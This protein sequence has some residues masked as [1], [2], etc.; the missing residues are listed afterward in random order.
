MKSNKKSFLLHVDSLDI[1]DEL[2]DEQAGILFKSIRAYQRGEEI[3]T[4]SFIR[5][6]FSPFKNQFIRDNEKYILICKARAEAGS[7]GGTAKTTNSKQKLASATNS[8]Q[9]IAN[10]ADND[11]DSDSDSVS[12]SDLKHPYQGNN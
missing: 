4:D 11:N 5:I 2:T 1:L 12:V 7:K 3:E 8:K 10:L 9:K 6:A